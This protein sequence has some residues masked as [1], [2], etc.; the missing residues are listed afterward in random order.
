LKQK[1][2]ALFN[3]TVA[4]AANSDKQD[5]HDAAREMASNDPQ[6]DHLTTSHTYCKWK[7]ILI[8]LPCFLSDYPMSLQGQR[9]SPMAAEKQIQKIKDQIKGN[10]VG[11]FASFYEK[12]SNQWDKNLPNDD[13]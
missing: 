12:D 4:A 1:V 2:K 5:L 3:A 6:P 13:L 10:A 11:L 9:D 7:P 8:A